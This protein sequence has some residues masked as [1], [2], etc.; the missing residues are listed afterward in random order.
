MFRWVKAVAALLAMSGMAHADTPWS[1]QDYDLYAG[2][3]NGDGLTDILY[4]AHSANQLSGIA[5]SDGKGFNIPLQSWNNAYLGIPWSDGKYRIVVA[6]FNGDG[7]DDLFLQRMDGG[8]HFLLLSEDGGIGA[9]SQTIPNDGF[10]LIWSADQHLVLAGDFNGDGRADLFLQP[11]DPKGLSAVLLS[12]ANGQFTSK[13]PD[14]SWA[15]GY[16]GFNW[17]TAESNVF[18]GDFNGDKRADLLVQSKPVAGTG[19]GT[20]AQAEFLP[21]SNGVVLADTMPNLFATEGVQ[22]WSRDGFKA[23]WSPLQSNV[24]VADLNGDKRADVLLQ[25]VNTGDASYVLY[26][27]APGSIFLSTTSLDPATS[28]V[29]SDYKLLAG[30]FDGK[31][32]AA[33]FLQ[34]QSAKGSNSIQRLDG[35]KLSASSSDIALAV[36][37]AADVLPAGPSSAPAGGSA[38]AALTVTS[39][40][41]TPG[42]FAVSAMGGASYQIPIWTPPGARG[43]EPKLALVYA[44]GGMDGSL[45]PGWSLSGLSAIARCNKTYADNAGVPASVKLATSDDFCLDGNRLRVTSGTYGAANSVYQTQMAN[46]SRITASSTLAGNGPDNF[47]VEGKDGL[48]YEYGSTVDSKAYANGGST[49]YA[50]MLNKV[51]DRQGNNLTITYSTTSGA[52]QPANIQYTQTPA[53]GTTYP[54]NVVFTYQN[55]VTNLNQYVAG[56]SILQTQVLAKIDVQSSA[57]SVRQY[58]LSYQTAPTTVRDRLAS[59]QECGGSAG[60]DCLRPTTITY[61]DGSAGV[62]APSTSTGSGATNGTMRTVDIDGDGRA[63]LI[64]AVTSGTN[65]VWYAQFATATGYGAPI[66]IGLTAPSNAN[67]LIDDFL[68]DGRAELLAPQ[69]SSWYAYSWSG[70]A[71]VATNTGVSIDATTGPQQAAAADGDGDGLP[72]LWAITGTI[73]P[74]TLNARR[75]TSSGGVISFS[76]TPGTFPFASSTT[77]TIR[78]DNSFPQ[79]NLRN[80]DVL[81]KGSSDVLVAATGPRGSQLIE[82]FSLNGSSIYKPGNDFNGTFSGFIPLRWNDDNC[83]DAVVGATVQISGCNG[84]LGTTV[85][86]LS[87]SASLALDWDGDG[88]TDILYN[89][90]GTWFVQRSLGTAAATATSTA[91]AV[92]SGFWAPTDRNGDGL[93]DLLFANSASSYAISIGLHNGAATPADLAT[94]IADGW[95]IKAS[96]TYVPITISNYSKYSDATLPYFD[97][98]GPMYVVSQALQSDGIGNGTTYTNSFWY[99][100]AR[101][102]RQ[103]R[104][105]AGFYATRSID[106]RTNIYDYTYYRRDYPFTGLVFQR[107][108]V[109]PN[110]SSVITRTV[111]DLNVTDI[112]GGTGCT[113]SSTSTTSRCFPYV[114]RATVTSNDL[115][116][117]A[118][119]IQTSVTDLVYD[120]YGNA[121]SATTTVTDNDTLSPFSG[122]SWSSVVTHTI[123]PD[124]TN[125][126]LGMP[127]VTTTQN[128]TPGPVTA[129]RRVDH[130]VDGVNCRN[131][132]E[133]IEPTSTT[134]K[135]VKTLGYDTCGNLNSVS[136]VGLDKNGVA[137]PARATT[138]SFGTRCTFAESVTNA[139]SQTATIGYNYSYGVKASTTDANGVSVSWLYDNFAR[140]TRESRPDGTYS[141]WSYADCIAASCW[142]SADL[143]LHVFNNH[144]DS[145]AVLVRAQE[146]YFDGLD[147]LR[148]D[149]GHR[150][151]GTWTNVQTVYNSLGLKQYVY[152]PYSAGYNGYHAYTYDLLNRP[153]HDY[154]NDS[155]GVTVRTTTIA[156]AGLNTTLTDPVGNVTQKWTDVTG[157]L[158]RIIDPSPGG[159]TNYTFDPFGNL[160]QMVDSTGATTTAVYNLRGFKTSSS[161]PDTG[162]WTFTPNSLNELITQVDAKGQNITMD[163]DKLGRMISRL[164]PESATAT[165]WT[166]GTSAALHEIGQLKSVSKPDGYAESYTFDAIGRPSSTTITEDTSYTFNYAY[167]TIGAIDTVT[168][169]TSTSS[170]R[171]VLKNAYSYGFLQQVK[172]NAT[173]GTTFW[174]VSAANDYSSPTTEQLGNGAVIT[175]SYQ[176]WT[177]DIQTRQVGTG[178]STTNLQNLSY[179]WTP[180]SNL[181]QRQDLRQSLTEVF[182][183]DALNRL[184]VSTLNGTQNLDVNYDAAGNITYKSDIGSYAY[185]GVQSGCTYYAH[186]QPHAVR[187]VGTSVY[188]YDANGNMTSRAGSAI[189]WYSYNQPN[190][191][192]Q[193]ASKSTT[194]SYNANH[195]RWKQ[196]SIDTTGT[197]GPAG[198]TTTYYIGGLMEK[199]TLPSGVTEYRHLIPAGVGSAIYTRR[200]DLTNSTYYASTDHLGSGDLIMDSSGTVLSRESFTPFGARRGSNWTGTPATADYNTYSQTTRRGF[201]GHE[202]LD[203]VSLIH[204]NGRVYDPQLGRFLSA[205][206]IVQTINISQAINPFSYV[207]N[208]PLSLVDPSGYSWLS[209]IFHA[210][211]SFFKKWGS[212]IISVAFAVVGLPFVGALISS[213]FNWAVNGG[214]FASFA[215]GLVVSG[216]AGAIASPIGGML[217]NLAKIPTQGLIGAIVRGAIVGAIAGGISSSV[218]G[219]SFWS[220]FVGG[221]IT[222]GIAAGVVSKLSYDPDAGMESKSKFRAG[223]ETTNEAIAQTLGKI[224]N[225]PNTVVGLIIGVAGMPFG[226]KIKFGDNA[227]EFLN[228]PW[229]PGGALTLGN[230]IL[231]KGYVPD[232]SAPRYDYTADV[233]VGTHERAH[234]YQGQV[235]GVLFGPAYLLAGGAFTASSPF[236]NSADNFADLSGSW[237]PWKK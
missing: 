23:E 210:I 204:M 113:V 120:N 173:G 185:T 99:Y 123:T 195:Q 130:A 95:G 165:T 187:K 32:S 105:F 236:E 191:I 115:T 224:W 141:T 64:F 219:G 207:M 72:D 225:L 84:T 158:R 30:R 124:V 3:F 39:A 164:E 202:M 200:S 155:S 206:P 230:V 38:V 147:R 102:N 216:A 233:R 82:T 2:D 198:T 171:L 126:C 218:M 43:I 81:G 42:Q 61:Q 235:L 101:V 192:V 4:I 1:T 29:A 22:A 103:G 44:S 231:F 62:A 146:Q 5:L 140:K 57:V 138:S 75:N 157:K 144:Y 98:I 106:S 89:S 211:G 221:A 24:V 48:K 217:G 21:N 45:G 137:M 172:D 121:T 215:I 160:T 122:Q 180:N 116:T 7:K 36:P 119:L 181:Q 133:T 151:L 9:I 41:R 161:D 108:L 91:I 65:N 112:S 186:A 8:D 139:L 40:G 109:Q 87:G 10:G 201:T 163:Y 56:G 237:W 136:V 104:G 220:G 96:P 228:Y 193:G 35:G 37:A 15:N 17:A 77:P 128:T 54:Y 86:S 131:S 100:G 183:Y 135:V 205:D 55:R 18:T 19:P 14:Q 27:N 94:T 97:F 234:T 76:A 49:P 26:G 28:P 197:T 169:P 12:D 189:T 53:T 58:N 78:G 222:G 50:W 153:T 203:A 33:L 223:L 182:T 52:I 190:Q 80:I 74:W 60:T 148:F 68:G 71:F 184:D 196:I 125:W 90:G 13:A 213:A 176:P 194:F 188:C 67:V 143:R 227:I 129:T 85:V 51:R 114:S 149:E 174:T 159:T 46:F 16:A 6:D 162:N 199:V 142:G 73:A 212:L 83:T 70:S 66:S 175:S 59:V 179:S 79:S 134:L 226:A 150:V 92:G 145:A 11:T 152:Q 25:G 229:G 168:Y 20:K 214:T 117:A 170:Y 111:N 88:R 156:Y 232:S 166:Y 31:D 178:A 69:G 118:P 209:K 110:G 34:S 107:D 63:D 127:T 154:L 93:S 208:N 132:S 47:V 167:N 177:N